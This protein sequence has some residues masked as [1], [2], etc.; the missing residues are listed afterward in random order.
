MHINNKSFWLLLAAAV[1]L[2]G[3]AA[4][5]LLYG[6]KPIEPAVI[7][8][9]IFHFD[10][11][12]VDHQIIV[13][14]RLPRAAGA[15][16]I[17][18]ALAVSGA[19][20][21]GVTRNYLASPGIM[22]IND[23]S[24]LAVTLCMILF[25]AA[26]GFEQIVFSLAGSA[27]GA[28]AVFGLGSL[29]PGGLSPVRL[30]ILGTVV[31]TFLS[32]LAAALAVYFQISQDIG[33]WYHARLYQIQPEQLQLAVPFMLA[34]LAVSL[35]IARSVSVL[36][37]GEEVSVSLGQRTLRVKLLAAAAV[38]LLTGSAVALAGKI[39]FVGLIIPHIVRMLAGADYLWVIP[40]SGLLGA[41]FLT[42]ADIL[43]RFINYPFETPVGV[44]T[45][46]VGVP[47]FLYLARKKGGDSYV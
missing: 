29:L 9:A 26:S 34:G 6:S 15:L 17:G 18:G 46:L 30:A 36:S 28:L 37:L 41:A 21:Q 25:P 39:A 2:P 20:M 33:Y 10:P 35:W 7:Q 23:G 32:S 8:A 45:S 47:F 27:L 12:N 31:G 4:L 16:L 5:S 3:L 1:S 11:A 19:L 14:S 13:T 43:S 40:C 24:V 42:L 44:V 38:M 22:G